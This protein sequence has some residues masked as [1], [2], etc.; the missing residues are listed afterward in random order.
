MGSIN[1]GVYRRLEAIQERIQKQSIKLSFIPPG[2]PHFDGFW[3]AG[4][5]KA[6]NRENINWNVP[7]LSCRTKRLSACGRDLLNP[8]L[9]DI[10]F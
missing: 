7:L 9:S 8:N 6:A 10:Y 1:V 2:A 3:E 5:K 4:V